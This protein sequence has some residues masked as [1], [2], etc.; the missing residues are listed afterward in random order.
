MS[1]NDV[2]MFY[3]KIIKYLQTERKIM[4]Y[5][6]VDTTNN[7]GGKLMSEK[8]ILDNSKHG[9]V[10]DFLRNKINENYK[11]GK[12]SDL[13]IVSAYFSIY[14]FNELKEELKNKVSNVKFVLGDT[15]SAENLGLKGKKRVKAFKIQDDNIKLDN[16]I[17]QNKIAKDC[18]NWIKQKNVEIHSAPKIGDS[19]TLIHGKMYYIKQENVNKAIPDA[20]IGSSNFT[21]CGLGI[22]ACSN[23]ELN[24]VIRDLNS[25]DDLNEWFEN[26]WNNSTEDAKNEIL[27]YIKT[28][29]KENS[30]EEV[31]YKT[32]YH[33]YEGRFQ[34]AEQEDVKDNKKFIDTEIWKILYPYQQDAV[35]SIVKK[36]NKYN[37]CILADSVGLGKTYT[38]LGVIQYFICNKKPNI[39]VLAPKRL[40]NNWNIYTKINPKNIF[41][42]NGLD[43]TFVT[44]SGLISKNI[45]EKIDFGDFDLVVIDESH[46]F[47]NAT[48]SKKD[49]YGNIIKVSRYDKLLKTI[50]QNGARSPKVLLLSATPVNTS[51]TTD[52]NNQ[53]RLITLDND[54]A[55]S[56]EQSLNIRSV[57]G[58]LKTANKA[59]ND[60]AT[61]ENRQKKDLLKELPPNFFKL[62]DGISIARSRK[63]IKNNYKDS[64]IQFPK[65]EKP[66][67]RKIDISNDFPSFTEIDKRISGYSLALFSPTAFL[68]D[69]G[70]R[71]EIVGNMTQEKREN[72]L[73]GMMKAGFLKRLESSIFSF[74]K[75]MENTLNK[76]DERIKLIDSYKKTNV[77]TNIVSNFEEISNEINDE[78][79]DLI[80][81]FNKKIDYTVGKKLQY[82]LS[83]INVDNWKKALEEDYKKIEAIYE[84]SKKITPEK[85]KKLNDLIKFIREKSQKPNKKVLLFTT[86]ADTAE[87]LYKNLV[88]IVTKELG[89]NIALVTGDKERTYSTY[90]NINTYGEILE[91][92]APY[93]KLREKRKPN[94]QIDIIIATDCISEGQ[95][96]QDCDTVV[97]YDIHWNPVRLIQRFGRIDRIGSAELNPSVKMICYWPTKELDEYINLENRVESR[98]TIA[99]VSAAADDNL[100]DEEAEKEDMNYRDLQLK[101][102]M[103][104][105]PIEGIEESGSLLE[106][107]DISLEDFWKDL[108]NFIESKKKDLKDTPCGINAIVPN[109]LENGTTIP[110]GVIFCLKQKIKTD[111]NK[112]HNE[113]DP[114]YLVYAQNDG[115]VLYSYENS[116]KILDIYKSLCIGKKEP[117]MTLCQKFNEQIQTDDGM[118]LYNNILKTA[119]QGVVKQYSSSL[120]PSFASER[121][122]GVPK[123]ENQIK[124]DTNLELIT[125]LIIDGEE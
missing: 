78:D 2:V 123:V 11:E 102:I 88:D 75:S 96:L 42:K 49:E 33:L 41:K 60:W 93:S 48:P 62:L 35:N 43:I 114:Y 28:L 110:K 27:N 12:K 84:I 55:F 10:I 87:Y 37:G 19:K 66:D 13:K 15:S 14:A 115:T 40:E 119:I 32:L 71:E 38:A 79:E 57:E 122:G 103:E 58:T 21:R 36:L 94:D 34:D 18:Y 89:L 4:I 59:Y 111:E 53:I 80:N 118:Q 83:E 109:K 65:R 52:L 113:L 120:I 121:R 82:S 61:R 99:D 45:D 31:Y 17:G 101:Q 20:V 112:N 63:Q 100:L 5:Y 68:K 9:K 44:H 24:T 39:L 86:Y 77:T 104:E 7:N 92:F 64:N 105:K 56:S 69:K 85:D 46:N 81:N 90:K 73:I 23:Y 95:N 6:E 76:I 51:L 117:F 26:L 1:E 116:R 67:S 47:R 54:N 70:K 98:M 107:S 3:C 22:D 25:L 16:V 29:Y 125:W 8:T 124:S 91:N 106:L 72:Y 74:T 30:P 97:N 50:L 108:K